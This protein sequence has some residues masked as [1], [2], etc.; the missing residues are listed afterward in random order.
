LAAIFD[1]VD[2]CF[3]AAPRLDAGDAFTRAKT[4]LSPTAGPRSEFP[5]TDVDPRAVAALT[6]CDMTTGP[7]GQPIDVDERIAEILDRYPPGDVVH[8]SISRAAPTL[9]AQVAQVSA[10]VGTA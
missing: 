9:R 8:R 2:W 3:A 6:Y 10:L 5:I 1:T 4:R 7:D